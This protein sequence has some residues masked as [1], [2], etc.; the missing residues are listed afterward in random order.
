MRFEFINAKRT[1]E[2]SRKAFIRMLSGALEISEN[3]RQGNS[4]D[5]YTCRRKQF[6]IF[7]DLEVKLVVYYASE[8]ELED[9][10]KELG[11]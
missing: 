1:C 5:G 2:L 8:E 3:F 11:K 4:F 9:L 6:W 10:M 7:L